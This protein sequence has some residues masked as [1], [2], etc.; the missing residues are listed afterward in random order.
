MKKIHSSDDF[1]G[2]KKIL[3]SFNYSKYYIS[4]NLFS[5]ITT[6]KYF[7]SENKT[8]DT[9]YH[10]LKYFKCYRIWFGVRIFNKL[11]SIDFSDF[12]TFCLILVIQ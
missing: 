2:L 6:L 12:L 3:Y 5:T 4:V 7:T 11:I 1:Y 10:Y 9:G 8:K